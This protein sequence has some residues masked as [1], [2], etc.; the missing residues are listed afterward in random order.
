MQ[1]GDQV[2]YVGPDLPDEQMWEGHVGRVVDATRWP[3]EVVVAFVNG[4]TVCMP[5]AELRTVDGN[6]YARLGHRAAQCLHPLRDETI[7]PVNVDGQEWPDG[8]TPRDPEPN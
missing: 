4:A 3:D 7:P 1:D 6:V 8:E 5:A 2:Q